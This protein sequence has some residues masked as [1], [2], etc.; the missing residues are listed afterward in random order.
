MAQVEHLSEEKRFVC[1]SAGHEAELTYR[2]RGDRLVLVHTGVPDELGGQGV[3]AD[4][5][6]A[7]LEVA[8]ADGLTVVPLCPFARDWMK[9]HP[10]EVEG[11]DVDWESR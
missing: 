6:R 1:R 7:A 3:A 11:L 8:R 9:E 10:E 5:V 2:L 4:L